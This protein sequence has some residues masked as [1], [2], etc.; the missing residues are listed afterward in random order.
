MS[1]FYNQDPPCLEC[2][3]EVGDLEKEK[4]KQY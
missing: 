2:E 4:I 1:K 3:G